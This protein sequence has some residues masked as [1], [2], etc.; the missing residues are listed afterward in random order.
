[1]RK[2]NEQSVKDLIDELINTYNLRGKINEV[3]LQHYWEEMMGK[4]VANRTKEIYLRDNKLFIRLE[5]A[6][7]KEELFYASDKIKK[8]LNE[9]L[10]GTFVTEIKFL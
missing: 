5:S 4:V 3:R 6:P 9:H 1:M 10:G 7:L 2:S 8:M